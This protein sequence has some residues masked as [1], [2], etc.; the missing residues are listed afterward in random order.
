MALLVGGEIV[1]TEIGECVVTVPLDIVCV[2]RL[3]HNV[4][5]H[6]EHKVLHGRVAHVQGEL[7]AATSCTGLAC[8][9]THYPVGV[10]LV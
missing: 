1:R 2:G 5:H 8:G 4:I 3:L 7:R 9:V 6:L 10:L